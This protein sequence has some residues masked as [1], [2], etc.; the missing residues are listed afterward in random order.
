MISI[1]IPTLNEAKAIGPCLDGL[2][3]RTT[4]HEI[5]VVDGGSRDGTRAIARAHAGITCLRSPITG[6]GAQMNF[7]AA[8]A[9]GDILLFLHADTALPPSGLALIQSHMAHADTVGGSFSL[10]F[11][12]R[13]PLL[14]LFARFSQINHILFTYG[15]QGLFIN[16]KVY[17]RIGGFPDIPLMEDVSIQKSLRRKGRFIKILH[18]VTTSA[19]RFI[20]NGII[21]QQLL[22]TGLVLLFY[23][24]VSAKQLKRFY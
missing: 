3:K 8:S 9:Q 20:K 16:R 24:G 12:H 4:T 19:R 1:I 23:L 21:R 15:D 14:Q 11:D 5:I 2:K 17:E 18:P 22:N 7:G 10:C 6:R 13:H